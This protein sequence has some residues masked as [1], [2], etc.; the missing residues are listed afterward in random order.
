MLLRSLNSDCCNSEFENIERSNKNFNFVLTEV[1][2]IMSNEELE[3]EL[4]MQELLE[5]VSR[6]DSSAQATLGDILLEDE[7]YGRAYILLLQ[8]AKKGNAY[9]QK[10]LGLMYQGYYPNS[11]MKDDAEAVRWF[12][13]ASKQ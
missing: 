10:K 8:S 2:F 1:K 11:G 9:A 13:R 4:Y 3:F 6:G 5:K 12:T 7:D